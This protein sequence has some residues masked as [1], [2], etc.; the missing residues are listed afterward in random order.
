MTKSATRCTS[1]NGYA[2]SATP[3]GWRIA[4]GAERYVRIDDG[5]QYPSLCVGAERRGNT[6][7]YENPEQLAADCH[8]KLYKTRA[9][10]DRA[11]ARLAD[12][13]AYA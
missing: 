8:A 5:R 2:R 9:G 11:A 13:D 1:E 7:S 10:F 6:I 4:T 3:G 12:V